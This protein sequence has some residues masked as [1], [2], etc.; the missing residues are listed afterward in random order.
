MGS[1]W[2]QIRFLIVASV[3][4]MLILCPLQESEIDERGMVSG[5]SG[6][7][8]ESVCAVERRAEYDLWMNA[9][10]EE[11]SRC[12][13]EVKVNVPRLQRMDGSNLVLSNSD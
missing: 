4:H 2:H 9:W 5:R 10:I 1:S 7:A 11:A 3:S 12:S 13:G 6:T 8:G